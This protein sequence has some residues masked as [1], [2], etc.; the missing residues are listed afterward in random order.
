MTLFDPIIKCCSDLLRSFPQAKETSDYIDNRLSRQAQEKFGFGYFPPNEHLDLLSSIVGEDILKDCD[1]IYDKIYNGQKYRCSIMND[2]QMI[3]PYK[4]VYGEIIGI[5]GRSILSDEQRKVAG[6]SKYKNT[7]IAKKLNLFGLYE[8]KNA[9][10]NKDYVIIVE[11]QFDVI[12]SHDKELENIVA[13]GS[14][15]MSLEQL[16]LVLRYT[17][18][19]KLLLD[20]DEAGAIGEKKTMERFGGFGKIEK[21]RLP[22]GYKDI[23]SFLTENGAEE[24]TI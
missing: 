11:G 7:H 16:A 8:A 9:I 22:V 1:L 21:M 14:S 18:N 5:V 6:I 13:L 10:L 23:D 20:D 19:I 2:Y 4:N 15:S 17:E 24:L 12:K 3:L